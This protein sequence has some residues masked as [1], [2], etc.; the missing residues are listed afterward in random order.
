MGNFILGA[1][2][3]IFVFCFFKYKL[4]KKESWGFITKIINYFK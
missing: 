2:A 3:T 4:W 1:V